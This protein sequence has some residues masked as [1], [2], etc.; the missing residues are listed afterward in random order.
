MVLEIFHEIKFYEDITYFY[1][2]DQV[3][4]KGIYILLIRFYII[5]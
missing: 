4:G 1:S 2:L 3:I 5:K